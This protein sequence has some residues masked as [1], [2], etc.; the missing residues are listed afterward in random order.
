MREKEGSVTGFSFSSFNED[1]IAVSFNTNEIA[2]VNL[3]NIF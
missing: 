2:Y 1:H 3:T